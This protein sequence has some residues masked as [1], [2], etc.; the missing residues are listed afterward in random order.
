MSAIESNQHISYGSAGR[1]IMK[2]LGSYMNAHVLS[3]LLTDLIN[4]D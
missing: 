1:L 4:R 2:I 3:N